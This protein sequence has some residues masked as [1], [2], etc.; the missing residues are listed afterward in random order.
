MK[1]MLK[2]SDNTYLNLD[3]D[4]YE[5]PMLLNVVTD[6]LLNAKVYK[7][8]SETFTETDS[9]LNPKIELLIVPD[10]RLASKEE[11]GEEDEKN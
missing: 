5:D 3:L 9:V 11:E 6:T 2:I 7:K 10:N 8:Y 1:Y 4:S